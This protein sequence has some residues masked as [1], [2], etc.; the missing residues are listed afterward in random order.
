MDFHATAKKIIAGFV[1]ATIVGFGI[2]SPVEASWFTYSKP[3]FRGRVIDAETREPIEGAVVVVM[4]TKCFVVGNPGGPNST[5]IKARETLTNASGEFYFPPYF[6]LMFFSEDQG[7]RFVFFKPGYKA[8][9]RIEATPLPDETYLAIEENMIGKEGEISHIDMFGALKKW[10][11]VLGIVELE[12]VKA[13]DERLQA[14]PSVPSSRYRSNKL[15]LLF[16]AINEDRK[17]RGLEGEVK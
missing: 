14:T 2:L 9:D 4:Y 8:I 15:P 6:S 13:E 1:M 16:K 7:A 10:K 17:Q 11:G 3:E 12:R 5:I